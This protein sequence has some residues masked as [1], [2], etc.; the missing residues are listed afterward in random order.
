MIPRD[1]T[2]DAPTVNAWPPT[3][4]PREP[5][6]QPDH[7]L[8]KRLPERPAP[9][10]VRKQDQERAP[11]YSPVSTGEVQE[12]ARCQP[13]EMTRISVP[14]THIHLRH[15]SSSNHQC[16]LP[17]SLSPLISPISMLPRPTCSLGQQH[18]FPS[19]LPNLLLQATM[20]LIAGQV[21]QGPAGGIRYL[22]LV[23]ESSCSWGMPCRY[24]IGIDVVGQGSMLVEGALPSDKQHRGLKEE[25]RQARRD[26]GA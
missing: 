17:L 8:P 19:C 2:H 11:R 21:L 25:I 4:R 12:D 14:C 1:M 10:Q 26:C 3:D 24:S 18:L 13:M 22:R 9:C 15:P 20:L 5:N 23:E 6:L 16:I 7:L